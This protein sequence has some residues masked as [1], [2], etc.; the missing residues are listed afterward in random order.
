MSENHKVI[1]G[2]KWTTIERFINQFVQFIVSVIIARIISPE[3]YGILGILLVFI[4]ISQVFIDSGLGSALIYDNRLEKKD[5]RT[6]FTFNLLVSLLLLLIIVFT[7]PLIERF[8]CIDGLGLYIQISAIVLISNSIIVVPTAILKVGLN[9]KP[10]SISNIISSTVSAVVGIGMV[11]LGF[12]VWGLIGQLLSKSICQA[13]FITIQSKWIPI[14]AFHKESFFKL[15]KYAINVFATSILTKIT[16]EGISAVIAKFL[17]PINLGLFTRAGQFATFPSSCV[18]SIIN[19]VLFPSLS[20]IKEKK[21]DFDSLFYKSIEYQAAFTIPLFF[22]LALEAK[23]IILLLLTDK[24]IDLVP[25]FQILCI[26]RILAI[27]SNT[28]EQAL[29]ANGNSEL[30]LRQQIFK[31][32]LKIVLVSI[33]LPY[34]IIAIAIADA[35]QTICQF[36]ITNC[37][38]QKALKFKIVQIWLIVYPYILSSLFSVLFGYIV[39]SYITNLYL[40]LFLSSLTALLIYYLS[41]DY[42]FNR[43]IIRELIYRIKKV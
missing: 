12:G 41:T 42:I 32:L 23:P 28:T 20:S 21:N 10:L 37:V 17:S 4:N 13:L 36:I 16:D 2:L 40:Q 18:G 26:G 22:I 38:A 31:L 35:A 34:G 7:A 25:I 29:M 5:L 3:E 14:I 24:W 39:Y 8:Y 6:T 33:A 19:N 30:Y 11:Y 9:F 15:Y 27:T 1:K 43:C